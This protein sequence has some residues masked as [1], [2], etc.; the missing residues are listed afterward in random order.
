MSFVLTKLQHFD[1]QRNHNQ[2]GA[3]AE[4]ASK[5]SG[6]KSDYKTGSFGF[7]VQENRDNIQ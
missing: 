6:Y 4:K 3:N 5:C 7:V 2:A 1:H